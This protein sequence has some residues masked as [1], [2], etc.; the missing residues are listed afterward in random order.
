M[1]VKWSG[2]AGVARAECNTCYNPKIPREPSGVQERDTWCLACK[3]KV[4]AVPTF[5]QVG[6]QC[7]VLSLCFV[8]TQQL[9]WWPPLVLGILGKKVIIMVTRQW[10]HHKKNRV[11]FTGNC[12]AGRQKGRKEGRF[13]E[14]DEQVEAASSGHTE[15]S[16]ITDIRFILVF[17]YLSRL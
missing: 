10:P 7:N 17:K 2:C 1:I 6:F 11:K 8:W 13:E 5:F 12:R 3:L 16:S 4:W 9:S 15:I 14:E